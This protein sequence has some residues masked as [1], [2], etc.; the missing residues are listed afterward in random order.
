MFLLTSSPFALSRW[1][2]FFA[3][4]GEFAK[5]FLYTLSMSAC[6]LIL[7][8]LLGV[9]FGAMSS[10]KSK[11]LKGIARVYVEIFQNTPL[12]VQFVFV[13][14]GLV[15]T[16]HYLKWGYHDFNLFHSGFVCGHLPR[17]LYR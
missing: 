8:F 14:Y 12:L 4:F 13:Y 1:A 16:C 11:V 7:A 10:S 5:G 15:K 3:N 6:A 9:V 2:N 17:G